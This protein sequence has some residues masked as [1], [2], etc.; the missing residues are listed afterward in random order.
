[1]PH[2][3][4]RTEIAANPEGQLAHPDQL[5]AGVDG[6]ADGPEHG[7]DRGFDCGVTSLDAD[8]HPL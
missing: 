1:M 4:D 6:L 3:A 2:K 8:R 7:S 5:A